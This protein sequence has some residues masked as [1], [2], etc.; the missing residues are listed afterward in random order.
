[1]CSR[2]LCT[3]EVS[4]VVVP[5][6]NINY[7]MGRTKPIVDNAYVAGL[8]DG[9]GCFYVQVRKSSAYRA[10][11]TVHLHFHIKMQERDKDLLEK[12]RNTVGCGAVY[13]QK[14]TRPNHCQCYRYTVSAQRDIL[15]IVIPFFRKYPLQTASKR[16]NFELF[17]KVGDL[18][19]QKAHLSEQGI[20]AIRKIKSLMNQRTVGLA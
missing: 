14:E 7:Y 2:N 16:Q 8:T 1:V 19:K 12:I 15:E 17:C 3:Q 18:V 5:C 6:G 9:E 13:M 4:C 20:E 11:H 10:G